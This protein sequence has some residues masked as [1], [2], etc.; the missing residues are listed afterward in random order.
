MEFPESREQASEYLRLSLRSLSQT[1]LAPNPL[2]YAIFYAYHAGHS[3]ALR[4]EVD[5]LCMEKQPLSE[6]LSGELFRR[7]VFDCDESLM[8]TYRDELLNYH[9]VVRPE[10][11]D[12]ISGNMES[13]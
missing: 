2:N 8:E 6:E 7:Y 5:W 1:Q 9:L 10:S 4:D 11:I 3:R 12:H 13:A